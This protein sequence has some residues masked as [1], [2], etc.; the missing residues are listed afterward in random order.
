MGLQKFSALWVGDN[1][2]AAKSFE[3]HLSQLG[4]DFLCITDTCTIHEAMEKIGLQKNID[5]VLLDSDC[6]CQEEIWWNCFTQVALAVPVVIVSTS[7]NEKFVISALSKGAA[8]FIHVDDTSGHSI[9]KTL[10]HAFESFSLKRELNLAK[11]SDDV[12]KEQFLASQKMES[13]GRLALGVAHDFNNLLTVIL[14]YSQMVLSK[15]NEDETLR[16]RMEAIS[17]CAHRAASI[18]SQFLAFGRRNKPKPQPVSLTSVFSIIEPLLK[19]T[20]GSEIELRISDNAPGQNVYIDPNNLMHIVVTMVQLAHESM[21][22]GGN[23]NL[24]TSNQYVDEEKGSLLG[25]IEAGNYVAISFKDSGKGLDPQT[26]EHVFELFGGNQSETASTAS[27]SAVNSIVKQAGGH[28]LVE[29]EQGKGTRF[30]IYLPRHENEMALPTEVKK[31]M[32]TV[33]SLE[34]ILVVDDEEMVR[35]IAVDVMTQC[36]YNVVEAANAIEALKLCEQSMQQVDLVLTD[37]IMPK[38]NGPELVSRMAV[39]NPHLRVVYMSGYADDAF[40]HNDVLET[41]EMFVQKPFLPKNLIGAVKEA[42]ERGAS[43]SK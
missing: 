27:L 30:D 19:Q 33:K 5:M 17:N 8:D 26:I 36:G 38:M 20:L 37:L 28:I 24:E 9:L 16:K 12:F 10:R 2:N 25:G 3:G 29:S 41:E 34:T 22:E 40:E 32:K 31:Q 42:L 15:A 1:K 35:K 6:A 23:V 13:V 14:N 18:T 21:P 11:M 39:K 4:K 43:L 7:D